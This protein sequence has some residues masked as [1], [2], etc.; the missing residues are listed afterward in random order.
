MAAESSRGQ[1]RDD[2]G[3]H[4][5]EVQAGWEVRKSSSQRK[6]REGGR[7]GQEGAGSQGTLV[8]LIAVDGV[9]VDVPRSGNCLVKNERGR[10]P[11]AGGRGGGVLRSTHG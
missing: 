9:C 10:A 7:V 11:I 6:S 3:T 8:K 5:E 2:G 4:G 1:V